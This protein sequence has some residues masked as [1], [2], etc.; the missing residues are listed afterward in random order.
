MMR[1]TLF[2][3][4]ALSVLLVGPSSFGQGITLQTLASRTID[5]PLDSGLVHNPAPELARVY[6]KDLFADGAGWIQLDLSDVVLADAP[7]R[8]AS[9]GSFIVVR[10]L[11]DN[12]EQ[13]LDAEGLRRSGGQS[14]Y[15]NGPI[16][17]LELWAAPRSS[18]H[19]LAVRKL[20][21][22]VDPLPSLLDLCG[23][24]T[25]SAAQDQRVARVLANSLVCTAF[26]INDTNSF[27]L[28]AG[29][30]GNLQGGVVQFN[31]P[32]STSA[33]VIV[34]PAPQ[35]Q[36]TV[37]SSSVQRSTTGNANDWSYFGVWVN[38]QTGLLPIQVY[39]GRFQLGTAAPAATNQ[40]VRI[41]GFGSTRAPFD[42]TLN[43]AQTTDVGPLVASQG[44]VIRYNV[45]TTGGNSGSPVINEA[46]GQVI[47]IHYLAGCNSGGNQGTAIQNVNLRTAI[48]NPIGVARSGRGVVNGHLFALGDVNNNFGTVNT[49]PLAFAQVAQFGSRWRSMSWDYYDA[50]F[51]GLDASRRVWTINESG[52]ETLAVTLPASAGVTSIS[53]NAVGRILYAHASATGQLYEID[54]RLAVN[55]LFNLVPV[56][57]PR[58]GNI[59]GIEYDPARQTL[60]GLNRITGNTALVKLDRANGA[61]TTVGLVGT[62]YADLWDLAVDPDLGAL[63]AI[64][65][66]TNN[67]V[68]ID[69][70]TGL[71][72]QVGFTGGFFGSTYG[73][74]FKSGSIFCLADINRDGF[75]DQEDLSLFL[76]GYFS[77]PPDGG[78]DFNGD[79]EVNG[80]DMTGFVTNFLTGCD[81][82]TRI[83]DALGDEVPDSNQGTGR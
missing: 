18:G 41:T 9:G 70:Q 29:H 10:S 74:A 59:T 66:G 81:V 4:G 69:Q 64:K 67:L 49:L 65:P 83:A 2:W 46:T 68:A 78:A 24:D 31:V 57:G 44:N 22:S 14:A 25:R 72:T 32:R 54:L 37:D 56:G 55:G 76:T 63:Y 75:L 1:K 11:L 13:R 52:E 38:S 43:G 62:G 16:V 30:C 17:R 53:A 23:A 27:F 50:K 19:R 21:A 34:H 47:G 45:D 73:L 5:A 58:G 35:D 71:G 3:V 33:G 26:M 77:T 48:N 39:G 12:A 79:G 42:L 8:A 15:F 6:A 60:W 36:Y 51:F 40:A 20:V 7:E 61:I 80:E 82:P 28:T